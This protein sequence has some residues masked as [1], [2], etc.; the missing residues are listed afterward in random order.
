MTA[1]GLRA[2]GYTWRC[3]ECGRENYTGPAPTEVQCRGC[4][5]EF[6]V[7]DLH[8]RRAGNESNKGKGEPMS[9]VLPLFAAAPSIPAE[10]D[11]PF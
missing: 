2:S 10:D 11:I 3:P 4:N 8:H 1:V 5:G 7:K 6:G 9:G